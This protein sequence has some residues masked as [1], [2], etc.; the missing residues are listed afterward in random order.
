MAF[1]FTT[2]TTS[3]DPQTIEV[4]LCGERIS[5]DRPK[6]ITRGKLGTI[7]AEGVVPMKHRVPALV[8]FLVGTLE[9]DDYERLLERAAD[10]E[11][12]INF[13]ALMAL[14]NDL[15]QRWD[16]FDEHER[17]HGTRL[18]AAHNPPIVITAPPGG[19][20]GE[21]VPVTNLELDTDEPVIA[22]CP[23]DLFIFLFT[24]LATSPLGQVWATDYFL[25]AVF[26]PEVNRAIQRRLLTKDD[27]L[28]IAPIN[29]M[30]GEL[31]KGW[32]P[33]IELEAAPANREQRRSM[34]TSLTA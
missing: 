20:P 23:K 4:D 14:L 18:P 30:I 22:Y 25:G 9:D 3:R 15:S 5:V 16:E 31:V 26:S 8:Q 12:P 28:D 10:R 34:G 32:A 19:I 29:H 1:E 33:D 11:D 17:N 2:P 7:L 6:E 27:P 13:S 21:D 24:G